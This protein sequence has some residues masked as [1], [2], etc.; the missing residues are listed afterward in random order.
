VKTPR[1]RR[2]RKERGGG[3]GGDGSAVLLFHHNGNLKK[4][5]K[6]LTVAVVG[7]VLVSRVSLRDRASPFHLHNCGCKQPWVMNGAAAHCM[8]LRCVTSS[9]CSSL[10]SSTY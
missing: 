5:M 1:P 4:L 7:L 3:G 6:L 9:S 8:A 2:R 10:L